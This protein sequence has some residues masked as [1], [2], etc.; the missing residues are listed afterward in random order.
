M[1]NHSLALALFD[2]L[3]PL[4]FLTGAIFLI[5]IAFMCCGIPCGRMMTAGSFLV[6]LG[7]FMKAAWKLLYVTGMANI[8]WMG[9]G[10]FILLS[11]GFLAICI[12]VIL[13]ARK[14]RT[15]PNVAV[16]L[17]IV[18]WKLPF[19]FLMI[20]TSL[21]AEGILAYIAFRRNLRP[22]AAGFIV[23]VMGILAMGVFASGDQSV[24]MQ[25][26]EEIIN[27]LGQSG[28]MLGCIL[29]HRDFKIRGCEGTI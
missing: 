22:A 1:E 10:Q 28:F 21:G 29:L 16:L 6:F 8:S 5:K 13:M 26:I 4:A 17:G 18:P 2:F 27:T 24:A 23:G 19:L 3:P 14:L 9:E 15:D 12:S 7:G 25:W 11:I 20:L